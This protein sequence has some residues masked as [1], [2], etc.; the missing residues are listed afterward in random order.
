MTKEQLK[1]VFYEDQNNSVLEIY[2]T[3]CED[4]GYGDRICNLSRNSLGSRCYLDYENN[5]IYLSEYEYFEYVVL[6]NSEFMEYIEQ[7]EY[8][9]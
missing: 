6:G 5:C 8:K 9:E 2:F 4:N 1:K 3:W 7:F